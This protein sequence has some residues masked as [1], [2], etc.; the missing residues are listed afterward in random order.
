[1]SKLI[2]KKIVINLS[3]LDLH[4]YYI[5]SYL[6][7]QFNGKNYSTEFNLT[8]DVKDT[9]LDKN[10]YFSIYKADNAIKVQCLVDLFKFVE[11]VLQNPPKDKEIYIFNLNTNEYELCNNINQ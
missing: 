4:H 5:S 7:E 3:N 1:M 11:K 6:I 8:I 9:F 2:E 10:T